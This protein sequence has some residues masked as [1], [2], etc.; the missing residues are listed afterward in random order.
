MST[1]LMED[2]EDSRE[3]ERQKKEQKRTN[4]EMAGWDFGKGITKNK[5]DEHFIQ[6]KVQ[7][8]SGKSL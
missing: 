6:N 1:D 3:I 5:N 8:K 7:Q 2:I 4:E